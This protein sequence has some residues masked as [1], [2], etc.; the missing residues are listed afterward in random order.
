[1]FIIII[2]L[3]LGGEGLGQGGLPQES[4]SRVCWEEVF[5]EVVTFLHSKIQ[6]VVMHFIYVLYTTWAAVLYRIYNKTC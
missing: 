3:F 6:D 4:I 1:M 5:I 2:P